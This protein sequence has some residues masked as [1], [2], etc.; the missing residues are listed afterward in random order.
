MMLDKDLEC[1]DSKRHPKMELRRTVIHSCFEKTQ[2]QEQ[3]SL[4]ISHLHFYQQN[5]MNLYGTQ[6]QTEHLEHWENSTCGGT[7]NIYV[8]HTFIKP[9]TRFFEF[10]GQMI[11][12]M[13]GGIGKEHL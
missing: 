4:R 8:L 5:L 13:R 9:W 12:F 7:G 1:S 3:T 2:K 6:Q 11:H 10:A